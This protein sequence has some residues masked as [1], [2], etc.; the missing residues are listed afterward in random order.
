MIKIFNSK[1]EPPPNL[2][3]DRNQVLWFWSQKPKT[4][5]FPNNVVPIKPYYHYL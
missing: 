5:R 3:Y 1:V 2:K 4:L